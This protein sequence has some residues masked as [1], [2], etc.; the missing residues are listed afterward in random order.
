[1][2]ATD[3]VKEANIETHTA[4]EYQKSIRKKA[5]FESHH[6]GYRRCY[7]HLSANPT[8]PKLVAYL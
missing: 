6:R 2:Q 7:S 3:Y 4:I 5:M 1:M 8:H